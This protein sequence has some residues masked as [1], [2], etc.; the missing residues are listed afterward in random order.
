MSLLIAVGFRARTSAILMLYA[1]LEAIHFT[2]VLKYR[3][4][5]SVLGAGITIKEIEVDF[6]Y[7]LLETVA[8]SQEDD[9]SLAQ[10]SH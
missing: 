8:R 2:T 6:L 9:S 3:Y 7:N 10:S 4:L 5:C 1:P